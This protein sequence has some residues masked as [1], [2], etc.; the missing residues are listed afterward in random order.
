MED[1]GSFVLNDVGFSVPPQAIGISEQAF[2]H[3]WYTLRTRNSVKIKSGHTILSVRVEASFVDQEGWEKLRRIVAQLRVVPF[4]YVEN[5]LIR[6]TIYHGDTTD[7]IILACKHINIRKNDTDVNVIKVLFDFVWFN[8]KPYT[9]I[10]QY[11]VEVFGRKSTNLPQNSLAWNILTEAEI[12]RGKYRAIQGELSDNITFAFR[13]FLA[14]VI[15]N[16]QGN[17]LSPQETVEKF[18]QIKSDADSKAKSELLKL[19]ASETSKRISV[20]T[21]EQITSV[22][23]L[24]GFTTSMYFDVFSDVVMKDEKNRTVTYKGLEWE[25]VNLNGKEM[26]YHGKP[27]F[28][29]ITRLSTKANSITTTGLDISFSHRLATIPLI[30]QQYATYQHIGSADVAVQI[31]MIGNGQEA[32]A[33]IHQ[34]YTAIERQEIEFKDIP[35]GIR[36]LMIGNDIINLCGVDETIVEQFT[37]NTIP[38]QIDTFAINLL[39]S[40]NRYEDLE[41]KFGRE[42]ATSDWER[43]KKIATKLIQSIVGLPLGKTIS[44]RSLIP[45]YLEGQGTL[46][47]ASNYGIT[48]VLYSPVLSKAEMESRGNAVQFKVMSEVSVLM[49]ELS[50]Y[51]HSVLW[52]PGGLYDKTSLSE[53]MG[54]NVSEWPGIEKVRKDLWDSR[55][56]QGIVQ[57]KTLSVVNQEKDAKAY[58]LSQRQDAVKNDLSQLKSQLQNATPD[59]RADLENQIRNKSQ[60]LDSIYQELQDY[61]QLA[62]A[63]KEADNKTRLDTANARQQELQGIKNSEAGVL[64]QLGAS[65][66]SELNDISR[67]AG[68]NKTSIIK[69]SFTV[70]EKRLK[71]IIDNAVADGILRDPLFSDVLRQEYEKSK[72]SGTS[73]A[74]PD[75]PM[76][77]VLSLLGDYGNKKFDDIL[78]NSW[79]KGSFLT[80]GISPQ[81]LIDPS[82]YLINEISDG[83]K[84]DETK[85]EEIKSVVKTHL[86]EYKTA[87]DTLL[88]KLSNEN[89]QRQKKFKTQK[90]DW[91]RE[92]YRWTSGDV[93]SSNE[94]ADAGDIEAAKQK[95]KEQGKEPKIPEGA[96]GIKQAIEEQAKLCVPDEFPEGTIISDVFT[97]SQGNDDYLPETSVL[98]FTKTKDG[99]PLSQY[100]NCSGRSGGKQK[101]PDRLKDESKRI[102]HILGGKALLEDGQIY[103]AGE[104]FGTESSME[105]GPQQWCWPVP[106]VYAFEN[107]NITSPYGSR[108]NPFIEQKIAALSQKTQQGIISEADAQR[109]LDKARKENWEHD[110]IDIG[111][112]G[113]ETVIEAA[114]PGKIVACNIG[115]TYSAA[116]VLRRRDQGIKIPVGYIKID[117]GNG[118]TSSYS[119]LKDDGYYLDNWKASLAR[120]IQPFVRGGEPIAIMGSSGISTG[121]H[122]HF[123]ILKD[124]A[125]QSPLEILGNVRICDKLTSVNS[126]ETTG[127]VPRLI[128]QHTRNMNKGFC[129]GLAKAWPTFKLYF[130][131]SDY[132]ERREYGFDDFFSYASVKDIT[133]VMNQN[134]AADIIVLEL[135]NISGILSNRKFQNVMNTET[136]KLQP[137]DNPIA[138]NEGKTKARDVDSKKENPLISLV[139]KP[140]IHVK[141]CL[142]YSNNPLFLNNNFH[143][144]ITEVQFSESDDLLNIVAQSYGTELITRMKG[145]EDSVNYGGFFTKTGD[146]GPLLHE[147]MNEPELVHFGRWEPGQKGMGDFYDTLTQKF[148]FTEKPEDLN[149]FAPGGST[150][151]SMFKSSD[152]YKLFRTTIWDV[153]QE[154]C[155]RHPGFIAQAVPYTASWGARMTMYFGMPNQLYYSRD[156]NPNEANFAK[157]LAGLVDDIKSGNPTDDLTEEK[158]KSILSRNTT[159]SNSEIEGLTKSLQDPEFQ[160]VDKVAFFTTL[161]NTLAEE[162][163]IVKPFRNYYLITDKY[164]IIANNISSRTKGV[165]NAVAVQ[166]SDTTWLRDE[167]TK[168]LEFGRLVSREPAILTMKADEDIS[169]EDTREL[170]MTYPNCIGKSQAKRYAIGL[171]WRLLKKS[172]QGSIVI[173]GN[174]AIKPFDIVFIADDHTNMY[175]PIEVESVIHKFN[176]VN[177]F[178]SE[179]TPNAVIHINQNATISTDELMGRVVAEYMPGDWLKDQVTRARA[180]VKEG[181]GLINA[182]GTVG[183]T[184]V[185]GPLKALDIVLGGPLKWLMRKIVASSQYAHPFRIDPLI[186]KDKPLIH[187]LTSKY[188]QGGMLWDGLKFISEGASG[189]SKAL[190][191]A[192]YEYSPENWN[193]IK[194][195]FGGYLLND[196]NQGYTGP[197]L[198]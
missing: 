88:D 106:A 168:D 113:L 142:G 90:K 43:S 73:C 136:G 175:G 42:F 125:H 169:D 119:H 164:D 19:G 66:L 44:H 83:T 100:W 30:G 117:H 78:F 158:L 186:Y 12:N 68:A 195:D 82:F 102:K 173:I 15:E 58:S 87:H 138:Q 191:N 184:A 103:L 104:T 62:E 116:E 149:I 97:S 75:F 155:I 98:D 159:M 157:D 109:Q 16:E 21:S 81:S 32:S 108:P 181:E 147:L 185:A 198:K 160:K 129:R 85:I 161:K 56:S 112:S 8:F 61:S 31:Q 139:V 148:Q 144:V 153:F 187:G 34:M 84:L 194:G 133:H 89:A 9:D 17:V 107:H 123:M 63:G 92:I 46:Y 118:W 54:T 10:W 26:I 110:G 190:D 137:F 57:P 183:K 53:I 79:N 130:I 69:E 141:L 120:G 179:I 45:I 177:G 59:R 40:S 36:S 192:A 170:F 196:R 135:T 111:S 71:E 29:R 167:Q 22:N 172:Y 72:Q 20:L 25:P 178:I 18:K 76:K 114:A 52:Y 86:E 176:E 150:C 33:K 67:F 182:T 14:P 11:R 13:E 156:P 121:V 95:L 94:V 60:E 74:Y 122:L 197:I 3:E 163:D 4:C 128:R 24:L 23:Q 48:S 91:T 99:S 171:L 38:G 143:G 77:E 55:I 115:E 27:L 162:M 64:K 37:L 51:L 188:T 189:L 131:E 124:G 193:W 145:I 93:N 146:T 127:L 1:S 165:F 134:V 151:I 166:Y 180:L 140:G 65:F 80:A 101:L 2:N 105:T 174:P 5:Q 126:P 152:P 49:T 96:S 39:V 7:P 35:A 70:Y 41:Q 6:N 28:S 132:G 47:A 50:T 154:M